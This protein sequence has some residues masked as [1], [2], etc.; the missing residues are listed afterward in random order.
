MK[1]VCGKTYVSKNEAIKHAG[2]IADYAS[3]LEG[4]LKMIAAQCDEADK[5]KFWC[6]RGHINKIRSLTVIPD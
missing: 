4:R 2:M 3:A 6:R 5:D 1:K